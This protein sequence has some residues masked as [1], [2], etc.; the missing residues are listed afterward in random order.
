MRVCDNCREVVTDTECCGKSVEVTT[1][2][3]EGNIWCVVRLEEGR[4]VVQVRMDDL[5]PSVRDYGHGD[6]MEIAAIAHLIEQAH[7]NGVE[8]EAEVW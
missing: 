1:G 3:V 6:G 4:I 8:I 5:V 2:K 7:T